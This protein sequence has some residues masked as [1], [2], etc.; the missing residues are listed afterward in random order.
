MP[1]F[2]QK[3][4]CAQSR[5]WWLGVDR[6]GEARLW[7]AEQNACDLWQ[8]SQRLTSNPQKVVRA[9]SELHDTKSVWSLS[10]S[11]PLPL[12]FAAFAT[13]KHP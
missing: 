4:H 12:L 1:P 10:E 5:G 2:L 3:W 9:P 8:A 13:L 6:A 7:L 11:R